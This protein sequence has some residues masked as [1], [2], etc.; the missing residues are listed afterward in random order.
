MLRNVT[1]I[2]EIEE[3]R[4]LKGNAN[5]FLMDQPQ[6]KSSSKKGDK[7]YYVIG[8]LNSDVWYLSDMVE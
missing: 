5:Y 3:L 7:Y 1:H 8:F 4:I 6:I 2:D